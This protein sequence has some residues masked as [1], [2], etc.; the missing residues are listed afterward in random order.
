MSAGSITTPTPEAI[1]PG[2]PQGI[3]KC[4][5]PPFVS[6]LVSHFVR[7]SV[8]KCILDEVRDKVR[9]KDFTYF[10]ILDAKSKSDD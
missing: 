4:A 5:I 6:H 10:A 9:D 1:G 8:L 3:A 2:F 7:F